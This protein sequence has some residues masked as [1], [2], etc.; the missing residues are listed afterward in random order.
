MIYLQRYNGNKL[1]REEQAVLLHATMEQLPVSYFT[2]EQLENGACQPVKGDL[3]VGSVE[4]CRLALKL[5]GKSLPSPIYYPKVLGRFLHRR[6]FPGSKR[7]II[8]SIAQ[9]YPIFAKPKDDWKTFVGQVFDQESGFSIIQSIDEHT[10]LYLSEVVEFDSEYR[11]YVKD[12]KIIACC[13]YSGDEDG[14]PDMSKIQEAVEI[15]KAERNGPFS[16]TYAFDWGILKT[17]ETAI[18][19]MND[20]FAIG[21]YKGISNKDYY[22]FLKERWNELSD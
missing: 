22:E 8:L 6:V 13:Q 1:G 20:A 9:G 15:L 19:E 12:H 7:D 3:V 16:S 14:C 4:A 10:M 11:V 18:V 17:G 5:Q 21:K 2:Y